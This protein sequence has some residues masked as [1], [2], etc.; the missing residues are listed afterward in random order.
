MLLCRKKKSIHI[1]SWGSHLLQCSTCVYLQNTWIPI[2]LS[3][4][5]KIWPQLFTLIT[6]HCTPGDIG[7]HLVLFKT[8]TVLLR[9]I[10]WHEVF[11]WSMLTTN[12]YDQFRK[13]IWACGKEWLSII[14]VEPFMDVSSNNLVM[15]L[16]FFEGPFLALCSYYYLE[17]WP[18]YN[19]TVVA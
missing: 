4:K 1:L 17:A 8:I 13:C 5:C 3:W 12:Y 2:A 19:I 15:T 10:K 11:H 18:S 9:L 7:E 6:F 16:I 14:Y